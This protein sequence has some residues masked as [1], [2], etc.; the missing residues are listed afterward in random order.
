MKG[1]LQIATFVNDNYV[2]LIAIL[3][4]ILGIVFKVKKFIS[5]DR[6][7]QKEQLKDSVD[8]MLEYVKSILKNLVT[9][10]ENAY[11]PGTGPIKKSY[12]YKE[13]I[14]LFPSLEDY[15]IDGDIASEVIGEL[16]DE[17][18]DTLNKSAKKNPDIGAIFNQ[19]D[20]VEEETEE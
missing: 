11:G 4:V 14:K 9:D 17:A 12:V 3:M 19:T 13:L 15:I 10:A 16:I 7:A 8:N 20:N 1:L 2:L 18:V 5:Q 6:E